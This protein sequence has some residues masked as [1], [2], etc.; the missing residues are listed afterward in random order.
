MRV[1]NKTGMGLKAGIK[2][3]QTCYNGMYCFQHVAEKFCYRDYS[4]ITL[5]FHDDI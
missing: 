3:C 5:L 2:I 4:K 1:D